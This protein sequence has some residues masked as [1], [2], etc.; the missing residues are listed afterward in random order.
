MGANV[1]AEPRTGGLAKHKEEG[2]GERGINFLSLYHKHS[3][4]YIS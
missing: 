4:I 2:G 1:A 3:S